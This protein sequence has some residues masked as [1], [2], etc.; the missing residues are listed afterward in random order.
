MSK[1][2]WPFIR[3]IF[4]LNEWLVSWWCVYFFWV[5]SCLTFLFLP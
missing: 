3:S 5:S 1:Y 4:A 2:M